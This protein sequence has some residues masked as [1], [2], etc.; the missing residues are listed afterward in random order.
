MSSLF[1][2]V[3]VD[4]D[5]TRYHEGCAPMTALAAEREGI[6]GTVFLHD[7][8]DDEVCDLCDEPLDPDAG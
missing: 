4:V 3:A 6:G 2:P 5:G 7:L 8:E 1:E